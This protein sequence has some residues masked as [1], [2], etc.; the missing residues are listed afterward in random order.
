MG[1]QRA[2]LAWRAC[3]WAQR[4]MHAH[5]RAPSSFSKLPGQ[6]ERTVL[7]GEKAGKNDEKDQP[8]HI[9]DSVLRGRTITE[10]VGR[11]S[12]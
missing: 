10:H 2:H 1:I 4:G 8:D 9:L 11:N 7:G 5:M 3:L 12:L 6:R